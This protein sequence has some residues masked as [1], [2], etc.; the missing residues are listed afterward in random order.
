M[1]NINIGN[2]ELGKIPRVAGIIDGPVT[3]TRL[4]SFVD[5]G[6]D[7]FEVRADLFNRPVDKVIDYIKKIR[8][9]VPAPLIGTMRETDFNRADRIRWL[10][11]LA[12]HVDC[13]DVELGVPGW[14]EVVDGIGAAAVIMV[15]EH[16]FNATPDISGLNDIVKRSVDQGAEIV[17]IATMAREAGDVTRLLRFTEDCETPLVTM[18]MGDIGRIS[19]VAAP[20]F[21]SLFTYGYLRKPVVPGQM[22]AVS[23][24]RAVKLFPKAPA[25]ASFFNE[26]PREFDFF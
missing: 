16:D 22:S 25:D 14:R 15:S 1:K 4:K 20:L 17:K 11:S 26:A 7:M 6:V 21:G 8:G 3:E 19:R 23:L 12:G 2:L 10:V 5:R 18:A 9:A 24:A 13:V